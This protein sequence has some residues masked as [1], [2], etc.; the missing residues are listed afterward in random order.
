LLNQLFCE[1]SLLGKRVL[2]LLER[3]QHCLAIGRSISL[4]LRL[5]VCKG[6]PAG[7]GVEKSLCR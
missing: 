5:V 7:A 3:C 1:I 2:G 4:V 6:C